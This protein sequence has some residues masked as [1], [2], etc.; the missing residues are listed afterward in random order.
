MLAARFKAEVHRILTL[1]IDTTFLWTDSTIVF[2][3]LGFSDK[4]PAS[5]A[6]HQTPSGSTTDENELKRAEKQLF[7]N[8]VPVF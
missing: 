3:T 1:K 2:Q 7:S 8:R 4:Q 5:D 6:G